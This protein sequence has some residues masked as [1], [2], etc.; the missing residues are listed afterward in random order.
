MS[1]ES[2]AAQ[3][4]DTTFPPGGSAVGRIR[5]DHWL[6]DLLMR[7]LLLGAAAWPALALAARRH[8]VFRQ[9]ARFS[10]GLLSAAVLNILLW[11]AGG[12]WGP[13]APAGSA[14]AGILLARAASAP[15]A[16]SPGLGMSPGLRP[17]GLLAASL[18]LA[19]LLSVVTMIVFRGELHPAAAAIPLVLGFALGL[20]LAP[21]GAVGRGAWHLGVTLVAVGLVEFAVGSAEVLAAWSSLGLRPDR[22]PGEVGRGLLALLALSAMLTLAA[23]LVVGIR[24]LRRRPSPCAN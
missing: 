12:G 18:G 20:T 15:E 24:R 8:P 6:T 9:A 2:L 23:L 22:L 16:G 21:E 13:P 5:W 3:M 7:W 14:A 11:F 17:L 1:V 19:T 4:S 10:L